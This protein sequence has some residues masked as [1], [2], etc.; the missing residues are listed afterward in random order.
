MTH[1]GY[2]LCIPAETFVL[3]PR[4]TYSENC[5]VTVQSAVSRVF[6]TLQQ[7]NYCHDTTVGGA[8]VVLVGVVIVAALSTWLLTRHARDLPFVPRFILNPAALRRMCTA[9]FTMQSL[10]MVGG[11]I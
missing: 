10:L 5:T 11:Y 2:V 1:Q 6:Y 3:V 9:S 7:L 4:R 8:D